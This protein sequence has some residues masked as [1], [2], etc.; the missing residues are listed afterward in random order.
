MYSKRIISLPIR[1]DRLT[2]APGMKTPL[3]PV[4]LA[5]YSN[6]GRQERVDHQDRSVSTLIGWAASGRMKPIFPKPLVPAA[7]YLRMSTDHQRYSLEN[8]GVTVAAYAAAHGY[9]IVASYEDA[10]KS[11]L[12]VKG[13]QGLKR[14]LSD[15]LTGSPAYKTVLI[16]DVSRFGRFQDP[17]E[18]AHYEFLCREA[19]VTVHYCAEAFEND[20]STVANIVKHLK[21]VMAGEYSRE[22]SER[23]KT[24]IRRTVAAGGVKGGP[25]AYGVRHQAFDEGGNALEILTGGRRKQRSSDEVRMVHG[26]VEEITT[27]R[28]VFRMFAEKGMRRSAIAA[29]LN[30]QGCKPPR[31]DSWTGIHV[32][33]V[34]RNEAA[35]GLSVFN[36]ST[37]QVGH[38]RIPVPRS[39]WGRIKVMKPLVSDR[40]FRMAASRLEKTRRRSYSND[41]L[42]EGLRRLSIEKETLSAALIEACPY[43]PTFNVFR[44]RFGSIHEAYRLIGYT[45]TAKQLRSMQSKRSSDADV[46][47]ALIQLRERHG[48]LSDQII[49]SDRTVP[50]RASLVARFG[51][52]T[53]A[54]ELA[55]FT[56]NPHLLAWDRK[57][58]RDRSPVQGEPTA[59]SQRVVGTSTRIK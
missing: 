36:Q 53:K 29:T 17:D 48:Y 59:P 25:A 12:T 9:E 35:L 10:G 21:R 22:L 18:A 33:V 28:E 4:Y 3:R 31:G 42:L 6:V 30:M 5:H 7:Q 54:Y 43:L 23:L 1:Q 44:N 26:P 45:Y 11:G 50:A 47:A 37:G 51:S 49:R 40:L 39:E 34:L 32:D 52:I 55:G 56:G 58:I 20:G 2:N 15:I 24:A 16:R 46:I 8:Q 38:P 57:R 27:V 19:G 13:R 41:E 14:L